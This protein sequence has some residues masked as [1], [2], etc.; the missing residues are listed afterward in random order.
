MCKDNIDLEKELKEYLDRYYCENFNFE[1]KHW[2]DGNFDDSYNYGI[3]SGI[4]YVVRD[5][6]RIMG[7]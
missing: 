2:E 6:K 5:I 1:K 3:E 7:V 4:Q